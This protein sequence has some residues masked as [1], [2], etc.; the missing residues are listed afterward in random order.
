[1]WW[2]CSR[3]CTSYVLLLCL[4][5]LLLRAL[6]FTSLGVAAVRPGVE[7]TPGVA[8][9]GTEGHDKRAGVRPAAV[10][11]A[12]SPKGQGVALADCRGRVEVVDLPRD[13]PRALEIARS[14]RVRAATPS[15]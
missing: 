9:R 2:E 11:F 7:H 5:G 13:L 6:V 3:K 4:R 10:L 1:M 15:D 14:L 8:A 12:A